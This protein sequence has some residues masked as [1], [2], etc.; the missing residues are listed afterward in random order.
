MFI[1]GATATYPGE[2]RREGGA[3]K[4]K[5]RRAAKGEVVGGCKNYFDWVIRFK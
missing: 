4:Q 1:G 3:E 2:G 5:K